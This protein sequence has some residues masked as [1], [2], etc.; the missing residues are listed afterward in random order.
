MKSIIDMGT[1]RL[2]DRKVEVRQSAMELITGILQC[3]E[4]DEARSFRDATM[5]S[6]ATLFPAHRK[7]TQSNGAKASEDKNAVLTDQH[8]CTLAL[9]AVLL[10]TPYVIKPWT[11]DVVKALARASGSPAPVKGSAV[12]ALQQFRTNHEGISRLPLK[13]RLEPDVWD[14]LRDAAVLSSYFA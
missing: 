13:E 8:A 2:R 3:M 14:A 4:E 1:L 11:G 5:E 6:A 7:R 12:D 9:G 10:S